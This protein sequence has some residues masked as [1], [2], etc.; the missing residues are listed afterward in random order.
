[1]NSI[2]RT[3][4]G[5]LDGLLYYGALHMAKQDLHSP[6]Y[7]ERTI[8]KDCIDSSIHPKEFAESKIVLIFLAEGHEEKDIKPVVDIF[9]HTHPSRFM[10]LFNTVVDT[11]QLHYHALSVSDW[12]IKGNQSVDSSNN[13]DFDFDSVKAIEKKFLC[14]LRRPSVTRAKLAAFLLDNVG[15]DNVLLSFATQ[16]QYC[17]KE[18]QKYFS[19]YQ[20]PILV[21]GFVANDRMCYDHTYKPQFYSCTFNIVAES[22][23]QT[24]D[25]VYNSIFLTEKTWKSVMQHQVP[26]WYGVPGLAQEMRRLGFDVFDD[27]VE[28]HKYDVVQDEATRYGMVFDLIKKLNQQYSVADCWQLRLQL[29]PRLQANYVHFKNREKMIVPRIKQAILDFYNS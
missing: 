11:K 14:L 27:I 13:F 23:S 21:D 17:Y 26:I 5:R 25:C 9:Q 22:S 4:F 29:K 28:N 7:V 8:A 18:Y 1:M 19:N 24:D 20:L 2:D 3:K 12:L 16:S 6:G 15:L 10:V